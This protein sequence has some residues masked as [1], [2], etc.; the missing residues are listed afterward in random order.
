MTDPIRFHTTLTPEDYQAVCKF[1]FYHRDRRI[2]PSLVGMSVV[3]IILLCFLLLFKHV[4]L[5]SFGTVG[6]IFLTL[7]PLFVLA[8]SEIKI[9]HYMEKQKLEGSTPL[10]K[11]V[12]DQ[13]GVHY[14]GDGGRRYYPWHQFSRACNLPTYLLLYL[15]KGLLLILPK[16]DMIVGTEEDLLML[17]IQSIDTPL[18]DNRVKVDITDRIQAEVAKAKAAEEQ[19]AQ[20]T[21]AQKET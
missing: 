18:I 11:Y 10:R 17:L 5:A 4:P 19:A 1:N 14:S 7:F 8:S 9:R 21:E 12:L 6:C 15:D 20:E 2:L 16:K 3:G 13:Q